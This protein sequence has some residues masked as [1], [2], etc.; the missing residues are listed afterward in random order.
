MIIDFHAHCFPDKLAAKALDTLS[1]GAGAL[2]KWT[3]GTLAD[4]KR[5]MAEAQVDAAVI[6]NIAV[7]PANQ[8]SV[9][10]FA[11]EMCGE[12]IFGFGSVHPFATDAF[13]ELGRLKAMGLKGLKFHPQYQNFA[14]DDPRAFPVYRKA[15]SL[16]FITVFHAGLDLGFADCEL[17]S[18]AAFARALPV[19]NGAPVVLAHLGGA[20]LWQ[21]VL[22]RLAG[23]PVYFDTAFSHGNVPLPE[24]MRIVE[25]HGVERIL[26][27]TDLPWSSIENELSFVKSLGLS[28]SELSMV[29]GFSAAKLLH[30]NTAAGLFLSPM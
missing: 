29:L 27:G 24:A 12:G 1:A 26:L 18:P 22:K 7:V 3:D 19:F 28:E 8:K 10:N 16:G 25:K 15:A 11:S 17:A 20:F 21:E 6:L 23:L 30:I 14:V 2:T 9:N 13:E 4:T 5:A